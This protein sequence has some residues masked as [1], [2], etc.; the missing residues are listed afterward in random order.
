MG[1]ANIWYTDQFEQLSYCERVL[2]VYMINKQQLII[3]SMII[4]NINKVSP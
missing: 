3:F 1:N 4:Y 2:Q